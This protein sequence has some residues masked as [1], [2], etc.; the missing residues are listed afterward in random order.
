M[1]QIIALSSYHGLSDFSLN[2]ACSGRLLNLDELKKLG[3]VTDDQLAN[4]KNSSYSTNW[5][6]V[7]EGDIIYLYRVENGQEIVRD[8]FIPTHLPDPPTSLDDARLGPRFHE[9]LDKYCASMP[10]NIKF[11]DLNLTEEKL[12]SFGLR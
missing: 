9:Y 3:L 1:G 2:L 6:E 7:E 12:K 5:F 11:E 10:D 8:Y 4:H